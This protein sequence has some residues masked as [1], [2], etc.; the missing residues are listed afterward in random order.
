[1]LDCVLG[2]VDSVIIIG[3]LL[4]AGDTVD[5]VVVAF[6]DVAGLLDGFRVTNVDLT[7][8]V[9][10]I[11]SVVSGKSDD[12]D[13]DGKAVVLFFSPLAEITEK[14]VV[15][16]E[17][18]FLDVEAIVDE[19]TLIISLVGFGLGRGARVVSTYEIVVN[20]SA[21]GVFVVVI[22]GCLVAGFLVDVAF[23]RDEIVVR[24]FTA[25]V[26]VPTGFLVDEVVFI[27]VDVAFFDGFGVAVGRLEGLT[28]IVDDSVE[29]DVRLETGF[30]VTDVCFVGLTFWTVIGALVTLDGDVVLFLIDSWIDWNVVNF[31]LSVVLDSSLNLIDVEVFLSMIFPSVVEKPPAFT[32]YFS[33]VVVLLFTD[34]GRFVANPPSFLDVLDNDGAVVVINSNVLLL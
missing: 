24:R 19:S 18:S 29:T 6:V 13:D 23:L 17:S 33:V 32:K 27:T 21:D 12:E 26:V 2:I 7:V 14:L 11:D 5:V 9:F 8:E 22:V 34:A 20:C 30:L 15:N 31:I 25:I 16:A 28:V 1:M 3:L 4:D 10:I